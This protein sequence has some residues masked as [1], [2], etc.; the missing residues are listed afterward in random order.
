M[1]YMIYN[2]QIVAFVR[3]RLWWWKKHD[4]CM[5]LR[6]FIIVLCEEV[7]FAYYTLFFPALVFNLLFF[8]FLFLHFAAHLTPMGHRTAS[9]VDYNLTEFLW[10][11][12]CYDNKSTEAHSLELFRFLFHQLMG[13]F[14][15]LF[16]LKGALLP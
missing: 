1:W 2:Y 13:I 4:V 8:F 15:K 3:G 7:Y 10:S 6:Y 12:N 14:N 5:C 16:H 11:L 9:P